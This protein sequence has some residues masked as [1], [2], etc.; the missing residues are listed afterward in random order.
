MLTKGRLQEPGRNIDYG[1]HPVVGHSCGPDNTKHA[2]RIVIDMIWRRDYA[3]VVENPITGLFT[4]KDL[5][6]VGVNTS[7]K[8]V[9]NKTL[10]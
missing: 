6:T 3:A 8:Q 4:D 10:A 7:I 5:H 1:H 9:Q 2:H